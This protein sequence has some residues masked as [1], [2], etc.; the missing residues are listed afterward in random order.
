MARV[1]LVLVVVAVV[2]TVYSAV[3][4]V[5]LERARVRGLPRAVWVAVVLLLP[6]IG[7]VL[8]LL[9]GR[10]PAGWDRMRGRRPRRV[11]MQR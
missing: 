3:D 8:W 6:P 5:V 4:C 9:I 7:G 11:R 10:A 1:G 2:F